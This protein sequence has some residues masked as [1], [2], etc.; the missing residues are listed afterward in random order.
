MDL[1]KIGFFNRESEKED[2][3]NILGTE[4][5]L[6]NFIYGPINSGKTSLIVNLIENLPS[7]YV[8]FYINLRGKFISDYEDFLRALFRVEKNKELNNI[9]KELAIKTEK[10]IHRTSGLP[11]NESLLESLF[12]NKTKEDVFEFLEDYFKEIGK[13]KIPVLIIDELQVIGDLKIDDYLIYKLFNFFIRLTKELHLC[14]VFALSSDSLFIEKVYSEAMLQGRARYLLV[15]DF[16]KETTKKFLGEYGFGREKQEI[17]YD[18]FGGKPPDLSTIVSLGNES[19]IEKTANEGIRERM[20]RL[21]D[22]L[23]KLLYV[24]INISP[25]GENIP[26]ER[27]KLIEVLRMFEDTDEIKDINISRGEKIY[28]INENILFIDP[29]RSIIKPQSRLDL[30]AIREILKE[31]DTRRKSRS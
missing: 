4:P 10:T 6:I 20:Y 18:Y 9:L 30:N 13:T 31:L 24:K 1:K 5:R 29:M 28:L 23:D 19:D 25:D 22:M 26:V 8:V 12:K 3:M 11:V 16:N 14:H 21:R 15:D 17:V 7:D 2:L 27:E